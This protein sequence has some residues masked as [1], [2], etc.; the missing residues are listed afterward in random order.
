MSNMGDTAAT[1]RKAAEEL[2]KLKIAYDSGDTGKCE[3]LLKS[4]KRV[5]VQFPTY[6]FPNA[7]SPTRIEELMLAR[8][9]L[10]I[11]ALVSAKTKDLDLFEHYFNQLQVYY[12][13]VPSEDLPESPRY[14][15]I[16]GLNLVRLL[17]VSRIAQFHTELEKIT[18]LHAGDRNQYIRFAILLERCSMEG[19][20]KKL[21]NSRKQAPSNEYIPVV[22]MLEQTVRN[23]V[24][25]CIP[26]SY[27]VLSVQAAQTILMLPSP[28][29]AL[30]VGRSQAWELSPDGRSF[31]FT[32]EEEVSKTKIPFE[33]M[34]RQHID[35]AVDLQKIV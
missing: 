31:V 11:G 30:E 29:H 20:Y 15:M 35:Y 26:R 13:D 18:L 7:L 17:V 8:E 32:R 25:R 34:I 6:L 19:S 3:A 2:K 1:V 22:E 23:E 28:Q 14:M 4:L 27:N 10:E 5:L 9:A 12:A 16:L 33:E 21:L 24:A